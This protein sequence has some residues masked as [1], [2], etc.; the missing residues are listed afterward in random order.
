[1]SAVMI[2]KLQD[3]LKKMEERIQALETKSGLQTLSGLPVDESLSLKFK[4]GA[5]LDID[6]LGTVA[7]SDA[8]GA[9]LRLDTNS[10]EVVLQDIHGNSFKMS[11]TGVSV[12]G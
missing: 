8:G 1:M 2:Q 7:I 5:K 12:K 10:G 6:H 4:S 9:T 11:A 3:R